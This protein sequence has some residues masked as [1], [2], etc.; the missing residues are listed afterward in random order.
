M[1]ERESFGIMIPMGLGAFSGFTGTNNSDD[2]FL[3]R[4]N[5]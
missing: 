2:F 3:T 1:S 5:I 4:A